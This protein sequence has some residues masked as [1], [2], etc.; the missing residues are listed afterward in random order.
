MGTGRVLITGGTGFIGRALSVELAAAGYEVVVVSRD[1]ARV[2]GLPEAV[3]LERWDGSTAA[4]WGGLVDGAFGVV[5]LAGDNIGAG[6]WSAAKKRRLR[7]SRLR[8][9]HAV[10]EAVRAANRQPQVV[11]QASAVGYY[12]DRGDEVLDETS[13]PGRGF[14]AE[15][16]VAWEASTAAV[17]ELGVR[18]V[19]ARSGIVLGREDGALPRLVLP[20]RV[21]VGGPLGD[22]RQWMPWIHLADEIAA[23]RFLLEQEAG[24]A[25]NL[26]A[27]QPLPNAEFGRSLASVLHRPSVFRVPQFV[28]R[29]ALGEMSEIVL[30][31][32]RALP[33]GLLALGFGFR[34]NEARAALVDLLD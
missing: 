6:R 20:Y 15:T 29:A 1:P 24:G 26:T 5:N 2:A 34:F 31:G 8:A 18:H 33:H 13:R 7:D 17:Q 3:R 21:F 11:I 16:C 19:V 27:P 14:L 30:A 4:G 23:L 22:G 25:F 9:G 12:G 32:Q 10:V 28:L